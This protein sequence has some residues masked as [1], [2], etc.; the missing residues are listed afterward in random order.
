MFKDVHLKNDQILESKTNVLL[1]I[2]IY[3]NM[4]F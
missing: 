1:K 2:L 4:S 3:K